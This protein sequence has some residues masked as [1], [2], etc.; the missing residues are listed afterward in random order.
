[1]NCQEATIYTVGSLQT[2]CLVGIC[3]Q[4]SRQH[5]PHSLTLQHPNLTVTGGGDLPTCTRSAQRKHGT[6]QTRCSLLHTAQYL[7]DDGDGDGDGNEDEDEDE[8]RFTTPKPRDTAFPMEIPV[9]FPTTQLRDNA[10]P[11]ELPE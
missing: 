10:F 7:N 11:M 2:T 8:E 5:M 6:R 1:M 4:H 3:H 9:R